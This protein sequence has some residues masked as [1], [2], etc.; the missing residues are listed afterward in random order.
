MKLRIALVAAALALAGCGFPGHAAAQSNAQQSRA[1]TVDSTIGALMADS[2]TRSVMDR[3]M[4][5]LANNPQFNMIRDW[6]L[7]R[8]ATDP[9]ARGLSME[10]L[11]EIAADLAA[12]Q[13]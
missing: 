3:H 7:R 9:H 13:R 5:G 12:A 4:P 8:L 11:Q 1:L 10:K 2:R 6:P